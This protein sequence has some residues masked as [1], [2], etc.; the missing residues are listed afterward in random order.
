[1]YTW[2][3][4]LDNTLVYSHRTNFTDEMILVEFLNGKEQSYMTKKCFDFMCEMN[5]EFVPVTT[6][7]IEQFNRLF[8]F[9]ESIYV[10][11][12]LVCNGAILLKNGTV[13]EEWVQETR[14]IAKRGIEDLGI[15]R[16]DFDEQRLT[17]TDEFMFYFKSDNPK[18]EALAF[19]KLYENFDVY[20]GF[21]KRKVYFLPK[22]INKG[23]AIKR[24]CKRL[25]IKKTM[26]SGD[27]EFDIP[28]L[29]VTDIS[30]F[31]DILADSIDSYGRKYS[32]GKDTIIANALCDQLKS[33]IEENENEFE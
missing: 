5:L 13:D 27:S 15:I 3:S 11:Y 14:S 26:S 10:K 12:A 17:K 4:D 16:N 9:R 32:L 2:F 33:I 8:V 21:D 28:M 20:I 24:Y 25:G 31:P 29:N 6:R 7:S 1:M 23:S 18:E 30:M 22:E 19:R